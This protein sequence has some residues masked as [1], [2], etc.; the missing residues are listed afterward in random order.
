MG[1][2]A[3]LGY[4]E[5]DAEARRYRGR[6]GISEEALPKGFV[7]AFRD[8]ATGTVYLSRTHD[9]ALAGMHLLFGLPDELI[10]RWGPHGQPL[11]ARHCVES[12]FFR[13]GRFFTREEACQAIQN[14]SL[15]HDPE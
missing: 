13:D 14:E 9:G 2:I 5:L 3:E 12:G 6:G 4:L 10:Q 11:A 8:K 15:Q 7:P 1:E